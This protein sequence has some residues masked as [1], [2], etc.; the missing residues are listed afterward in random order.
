M[1]VVVLTGR[2]THDPELR[3]TGNGTAVC[4]FSIAVNERW[5]TKDG[6]AKERVEFVPV[7]VWGNQATN[8][9]RYLSKGHSVSVMGRM[10]T[11]S[12]D[13]RDGIARKKTEVVA[14]KVEFGERP[15][16]EQAPR[17]TVDDIPF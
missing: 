11:Q 17:P 6:E 8:C 14:D 13:D 16:I 1:N 5:K 15:K 4:N 7:V 3:E 9:S 12:Y 10:Q 2:L